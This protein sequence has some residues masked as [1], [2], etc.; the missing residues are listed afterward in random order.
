MNPERQ[1]FIGIGS[2]LGERITSCTRA[3]EFIDAS[4]LCRVTERSGWYETEPVGMESSNW[5][6]NAVAEVMTRLLPQ[7]FMD[8][9]LETERQLGRVRSG[10][11]DRT[12]DLD[13]L[14]YQGVTLGYEDYRPSA[15]GPCFLPDKNRGLVVPHPA[16]P[17]RQFV[18][19]P[20]AEIAP[21][22]CIRPWGRTVSE[23]LND[24]SH[25]RTV[26]RRFHEDA[27][28]HDGGNITGSVME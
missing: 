17:T 24:A 15:P 20:W 16:I 25:T 21:D 1:T 9:L 12:V 10:C 28:L 8:M 18:L 5:F 4:P 26:V 27:F 22:L 2:N 13:L 11:L 14:Y 23:M 3:L 7:E 19:A 6:I